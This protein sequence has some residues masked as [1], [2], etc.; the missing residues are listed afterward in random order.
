MSETGVYNLT[1]KTFSAGVQ[2]AAA[3]LQALTESLDKVSASHSRNKFVEL[4]KL[5][6]DSVYARYFNPSEYQKVVNAFCESPIP[7]PYA[8]FQESE[9]NKVCLYYMKEDE[10]VVDAIFSKARCTERSL[11]SNKEMTNSFLG[12][13]LI[14]VKD[15]TE[16]QKNTLNSHLEAEGLPHSVEK[17]KFVDGQAYYAIQAIGETQA[18]ADIVR[19][20]VEAAAI[21]SAGISARYAN[22]KI[23]DSEKV[24][25]MV[26]AAALS[27]GEYIVSA[28]NPACFVQITTSGYSYIEHGVEKERVEKT[29]G[30]FSQSLFNRIQKMPV[31]LAYPDNSF[32]QQESSALL[33]EATQ[34]MNL[35]PVGKEDKTRLALEEKARILVGLKMGLDNGGQYKI[36]SSFFNN[37]VSFS[38]FFAIEQINDAYEATMGRSLDERSYKQYIEAANTLDSAPSSQKTYVKNYISDIYSRCETL[39][40]DEHSVEYIPREPVGYGLDDLG[41]DRSDRT[42]DRLDDI[43]LE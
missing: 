30:K 6:P 31:P 38:E 12:H 17:T 22:S 29:S 28:S 32:M 9:T 10:S 19:K 43:T 23:H 4:A 37:D 14:V 3:L 11:F 25:Q 36:Q 7:V 1:A 13:R 8:I 20:G 16:Q 26:E 41:I 35:I 18:Q 34:R 24:A 42:S 15:L 33:N 27:G 5:N 2:A 39:L 21:Q 40:S